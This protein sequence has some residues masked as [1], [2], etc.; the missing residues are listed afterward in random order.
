MSPLPSDT[1]I[2]VLILPSWYPTERYPT[3]GIFCQEQA[4]ALNTLAALDVLVLFVDRTPIREWLRSKGRRG[5]LNIEQGL[6]VYRVQMPRLPGLWPVLYAVW[7]LASMWRLGRRF[8]FKPDLLHAHVALPAGLAGAAAKRI[9][10]VRLVLTE[11]TGPFSML[12][13]NRFAKW[14][15]ALALRSAD[16]VIAVSRALRNQIWEH[17]QLRRHIDIIPNVVDVGA[18]SIPRTPYVPGRPGRLLFIGEMETSIKGADFLLGA[19]SILQ[20]EGQEVALDLVGK[21]RNRREYESLARQLAVAG[22]CRFL[23][24]V[25]HEEIA[26]MMAEADLLVLPSLAETFGV[27]VVEALSAGLPVVATRCGGPEE[28]ITPEVGVLVEPANSAALAAGISDMLGRLETF[29]EAD[30]RL[31]AETHYGQ[32]SVA[33]KLANL[34]RQVVS[35]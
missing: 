22:R 13:R 27:V 2:K 1:P 23:D 29:K 14:A 32:A 5:R 35:S 26:H 31:F 30:L 11:H 18:F 19:V 28:T 9:F 7:A 3:G 25:S 20:K 12:M 6:R 17:P 24:P 21:G 10:G 4:R 34:Y 16:R 33:A 8:G 15:T